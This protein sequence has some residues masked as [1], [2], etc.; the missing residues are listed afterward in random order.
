MPDEALT[1][2]T[3][4]VR[5]ISLNPS[6]KRLSEAISFSVTGRIFPPT[7]TPIIVTVNNY[8]QI[9]WLLLLGVATHVQ[10][11]DNIGLK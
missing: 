1:V 5:G 6:I 2:E 11:I 9:I 7:N 4:S 3:K 8:K 10:N